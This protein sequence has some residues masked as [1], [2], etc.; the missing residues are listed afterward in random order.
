MSMSIPVAIFA[1]AAASA[2]AVSELTGI[3]VTAPGAIQIAQAIPQ[4]NHATCD[5][6]D[7]SGHA[8][9]V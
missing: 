9:G 4:S 7:S 3:V 1:I 8:S 5:L 2:A 6:G